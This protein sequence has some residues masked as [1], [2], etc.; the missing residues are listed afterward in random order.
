M[1]LTSTSRALPLFTATDYVRGEP[2]QAPRTGDYADFLEELHLLGRGFSFRELVRPIYRDLRGR[3]REPPRD[4][5][6]R[7]VPT[8][9]VAND[10]RRALCHEAGPSP[11]RGLRVA[12]AF[13][14]RGGAPRSQHKVN[15]ALDLDLLPA[16]S[17]HTRRYYQAAVELWCQYGK[18]LDMGLGLYCSSRGRGGIRVHIDTGYRCRTWQISGGRSLRP[19]V[20]LGRP[21]PLAV[22]LAAEMGLTPPFAQP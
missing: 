22:D 14:P 11:L 3:F 5:W 12:A 4:L 17:A 21:Q 19:Y 18:E 7:I 6:H 1:Q 16:D 8:L 2:I 20:H 9:G 10:L 15:A 13:R